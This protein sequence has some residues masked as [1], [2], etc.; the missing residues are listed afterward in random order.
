MQTRAESLLEEAVRLYGSAPRFDRHFA[1]AKLRR[2]PVYLAVLRGGWLPDRGTLLD[3]GC[4]RGLLLALLAV[5]GT[6]R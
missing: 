6:G 4:G 1:R 3:L 5:A 2:D